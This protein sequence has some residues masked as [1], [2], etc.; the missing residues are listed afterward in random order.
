MTVLFAIAV[1]TAP[2]NENLACAVSV[3]AWT[4]RQDSSVKRNRS[5]DANYNPRRI[6]KKPAPRKQG[7]SIYDRVKTEREVRKVPSGN[8]NWLKFR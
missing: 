4:M 1:M 3:L 5:H 7:E 8:C 2:P 6:K